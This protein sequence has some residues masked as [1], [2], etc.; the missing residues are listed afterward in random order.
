MA[1]KKYDAAEVLY[2]E[3]MRIGKEIAGEKTVYYAN[4]LNNLGLL[5]KSQGKFAKAEPLYRDALRI[6]KETQGEKDTFYATSLNNLALLFVAQKQYEKAEPFLIDALRIHK[7]ALGENHPEYA[8]VLSN[9][10]ALYCELNRPIE[11]EPLSREAV[12]IVQDH[13]EESAG[14]QS[15]TDQL[16]HVAVSRYYLNIYLSIPGADSTALYDSVFRWHGA[17]TARQTFARVASRASPVVRA[18]IDQLRDVSRQMNQLVQNP[19]QAMAKADQAKA[20][21]EFDAQKETLE[22][23]LASQSK[24]FAAYLNHLKQTPAD[25]QKSLPEDTAMIDFLVHG[26][27]TSAFIITKKSIVR[28]P[29]ETGK[30]LAEEITAFTGDLSL[31]RTRPVPATKPE[32][33]IAFKLRKRI[34]EPLEEHLK[35]VTR[36]LICP[37]GALCRVP[38][39]AL[40]GADPT[41]YLLEELSIVIVPVPQLLPGLLAVEAKKFSGAPTLLAVGD[42][43]FDGD[44][45][46]GEKPKPLPVALTRSGNGLSWNPLPNT[47]GEVEVVEV[48]FGKLPQATVRK[49]TGKEATEAALERELSKHRFVHLA[50]HGFFT[51]PKMVRQFQENQS[52]G[53]EKIL[54]PTIPPGLSSGIVCAGANKPTFQASGVITATQIAELDLRNVELAVLSACETSLGELSGGEGVLGLQRALQMAGAR[55]T[56]T[57]MWAVFDQ[58]TAELMKRMYVNRLENGLAAAEALREAQLWV[59]N[60]GEKV[61]AF[62]EKPAGTKRTP[63]KFWA[64]FSFAGDWR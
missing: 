8:G 52:A 18:L 9:L 30:E 51:P 26:E 61:G 58:S 40:P 43:D 3:A 12:R 49:L 6:I 4:S 27:T 11:A 57:T 62:P 21:K 41:K 16:R 38:F 33:D 35:G 63:P 32:G 46:A 55:A 19:P 45:A 20:I 10:G 60:N 5:Y 13:L 24:D 50:T 44:P 48:L 2:L 64:A 56:I 17:V 22:K 59:L 31:M 25:L 7:S 29:L 28:V 14:V 54:L 15:E 39:A 36:V 1:Q 53:D 34:W 37:D 23:K 42:V 47:K